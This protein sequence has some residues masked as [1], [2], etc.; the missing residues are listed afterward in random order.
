VVASEKKAA[1]AAST[2][3]AEQESGDAKSAGTV[4]SVA[5]VEVEQ[6]HA[7]G[8]APEDKEIPALLIPACGCFVTLSGGRATENNASLELLT[9]AL[10]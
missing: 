8:S 6:T 2:E 9:K 7:R 5:N 10:S 3:L 1:R 4:E